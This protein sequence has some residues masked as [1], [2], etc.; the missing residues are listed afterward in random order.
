MMQQAAAQAGVRLCQHLSG[1]KALRLTLNNLSD[2][3]RNRGWWAVP[4][5]V[6]IASSLK[7][8]HQRALAA[9]PDGD[10][11]K[12]IIFWIGMNDAGDLECAHF[13]H[14][15]GAEDSCGHVIFQSGQRKG[16]LIGGHHLETFALQGI[17]D[18]FCKINVTVDEQNLGRAA[19]N[20]QDE[21]SCDAAATRAGGLAPGPG[22]SAPIFKTSITS[23]SWEIQ[24]ETYAASDSPAG[25]IS[26]VINSH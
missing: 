8:F 5:D 18:A 6:V 26:A 16:S 21:A 4:V 17:R 20:H 1:V 14:V 13:A 3:R 19:G 9:V 23:P 24:P 15:G 7:G 12:L 10:D 22:V 11:R 2:V 25:D